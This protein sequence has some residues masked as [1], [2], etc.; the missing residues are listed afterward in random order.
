MLN[1]LGR[2]KDKLNENFNREKEN[3]KLPPPQR[4]NRTEEPTNNS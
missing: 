1:E 3:I 4:T 2:R